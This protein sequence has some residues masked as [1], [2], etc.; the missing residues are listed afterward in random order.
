[1]HRDHV[2]AHAACFNILAQLG[3]LVV[4]AVPAF[5]L[6]DSPRSG[7]RTVVE[8][9]AECNLTAEVARMGHQCAK[10]RAPFPEPVVRDHAPE[11]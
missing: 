5:F 2:L 6:I 1:M 9:D 7:S 10:V 8:S 11:D 3:L 4:L